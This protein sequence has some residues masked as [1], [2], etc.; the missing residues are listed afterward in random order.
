M[1]GNF[2]DFFFQNCS[3]FFFFQTNFQEYHL[4][5]HTVWIQIRPNIVGPDLGAWNCYQQAT[6]MTLAGEKL[7]DI[8][9][10][11]SPRDRLDVKPWQ[12]MSSVDNLC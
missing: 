8:N 7:T 1:L 3:N 5:C 11:A 2:A 12:V 4:G 6:L 10:W 9:I